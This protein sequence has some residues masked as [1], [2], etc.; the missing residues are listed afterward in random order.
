MPLPTFPDITLADLTDRELA[1]LSD[2]HTRCAAAAGREITRRK[3][4]LERVLAAESWRIAEQ[5]GD[6]PRWTPKPWDSARL[7]AG[8]RIGMRGTIFGLCEDGCQKV[9]GRPRW[10]L[11]H[12]V[13]RTW[14]T[15]VP[16][17]HLRPVPTVRRAGQ[18][19][20]DYA[21]LC[22]MDDPRE[23]LF[24][25]DANPAGNRRSRKS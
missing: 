1:A 22:C 23:R 14:V 10:R 15:C 4:V 8:P 9:D 13:F 6:D 25:A 16:R 21:C 17:E 18:P 3:A 24:P 12:A 20:C 19:R 5:A 2:W 7:C 11:Y